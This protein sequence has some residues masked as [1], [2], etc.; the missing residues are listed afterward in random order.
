MTAKQIWF[1][2]THPFGLCLKKIIHIEHIA[3]IT[4]K[5]S[6]LLE[7][8]TTDTQLYKFGTTDLHF[9]LCMNKEYDTDGNE[10]GPCYVVESLRDED[11]FDKSRRVY[12]VDCIFS[13]QNDGNYYS[14]PVFMD[15]GITIESLPESVKALLAPAL[16]H[17]SDCST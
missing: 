12:S 6:F 3:D 10:K 1:D 4:H 11:C 13:K 5:E 15:Q 2:E 16:I 8:I 7:E 17:D 9:T 14:S